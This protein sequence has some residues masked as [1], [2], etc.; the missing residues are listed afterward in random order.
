MFYSRKIILAL[1]ESQN[2]S[3]EKIARQ[4]LLFVFS[5]NQQKPEYDF[6]PYLFGCFSF[7]ASADLKPM[8]NREILSENTKGCVSSISPKIA[9]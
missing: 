3:I 4:K 9:I 7:S 6:V 8:V 1:L 5:K 2:G